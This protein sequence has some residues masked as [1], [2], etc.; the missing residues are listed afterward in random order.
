MH[1]WWHFFLWKPKADTRNLGAALAGF[2]PSAQRLPW[3]RIHR[4]N[5]GLCLSSPEHEGTVSALFVPCPAH[6]CTQDS[7][8][9][10]APCSGT[11][12]LLMLL[13]DWTWHHWQVQELSSDPDVAQSPS[14]LGYSFAIPSLLRGSHSSKCHTASPNISRPFLL[15]TEAKVVVEGYGLEPA[16]N[17]SVW[18]PVS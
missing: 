8:C 4:G 9:S 15:L 11:L 6:M 2:L 17:L 12:L 16:A 7:Q 3:C 18:L 14:E 5:S 13:C 1:F 10:Q